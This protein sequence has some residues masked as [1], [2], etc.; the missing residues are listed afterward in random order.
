MS[1]IDHYRALAATS[2]RQAAEAT[3]PSVR[4]R[5]ERSALA[6]EAIVAQMLDTE[7][8]AATNSAAKHAA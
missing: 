5:C 6:W 4:D 7:A 8:L 2:R 3:L 1:N